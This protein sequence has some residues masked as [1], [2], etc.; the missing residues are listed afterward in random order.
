[1]TL[2]LSRSALI[3]L[4]AIG[5][6]L[7]LISFPLVRA[8]P[9]APADQPRGYL[10]RNLVVNRHDPSD[11]KSPPWAPLIDTKLLNPW[12]AAIRSAGLGGHIWLANAGSSSVTEYVGD[13]FDA[14]GRFVELYQ[15]GLK[16]VAAEGSPIGQV[17]SSSQS[18]FPVTGDFCYDDGAAKCD[19]QEPSY[20]GRFTGPSRFIVNTEEGKILAWT[21]RTIDGKMARVRQFVTVVDNSRRGAL[22]RGL[23]ISDHAS[24]NRLYA[25]NFASGEI[26][27]YT[28][29]WQELWRPIAGSTPAATRT[30]PTPTRTLAPIGLP[31]S[32]PVPT[33]APTSTPPAGAAPSGAQALF[34]RPRDVPVSYNPFNVEYR[35]GRIYVT[36]AYLI[37][38]GDSDYDP[39]EPIKERTC[40]GCGYVAEFDEQGNHLRTLEGQKDLNAP[41]GVAIAPADFGEFSNALLVGNFGDGTIVAF[42]RTSGRQLGVMRSPSGDPIKI[43]GLWAI[44]FGNGASLG[45]ANYLYF[46]AGLNDEEDGLFGT[47]S[48][49]GTQNPS[50]MPAPPAS[51]SQLPR[52]EN[53]PAR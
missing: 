29:Q 37:R 16:I 33:T 14:D 34:Q 44:Y 41:W 42:D 46:T 3:L 47:L 5:V 22:Y 13:V 11:P 2:L 48:W 49:V 39:T 23:A 26:E 15:D 35:G 19:P 45:R 38:P 1:M 52:S 7:S 21:E 6:I 10:Q 9:Q 30:A 51:S 28:S 18:D 25:A 27:V 24:G 20:A 31:T 32:A 12:G 17:F 4:C 8:Q 50:P 53:G 36:Y 40:A 43:E